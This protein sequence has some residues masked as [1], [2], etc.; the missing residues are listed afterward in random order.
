MRVDFATQNLGASPLAIIR[1]EHL[2]HMAGRE[3]TLTSTQN[4]TGAPA[5]AGKRL[6]V[7]LSEF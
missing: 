5:L 1:T 2:S 3:A 6:Q 4:D 7:R